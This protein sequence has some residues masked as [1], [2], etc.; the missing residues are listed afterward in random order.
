MLAR[1]VGNDDS[2]RRAPAALPMAK[3]PKRPIKMTMLRY[4]ARRRPNV[5]PNRY[6][7]NRRTWPFT[8][9]Q[10]LAQAGPLAYPSIDAPVR[11]V[12]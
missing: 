10:H 4:P 11:P 12:P 7:A 2:V 8:E 1:K 6:Q 3:P 5:A 9:G